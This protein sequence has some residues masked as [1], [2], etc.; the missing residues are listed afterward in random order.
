M[1]CSKQKEEIC[2]NFMNCYL[3]NKVN[4]MANF[5][6]PEIFKSNLMCLQQFYVKNMGAV[7]HVNQGNIN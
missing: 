1:E 6:H 7:D 4:W 2:M 5:G 3:L